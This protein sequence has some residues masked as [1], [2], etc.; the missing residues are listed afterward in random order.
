M[1][2]TKKHWPTSR[3]CAHG[4]VA[5]FAFVAVALAACS[6]GTKEGQVPT[7]SQ[8]N[9]V[10]TRLDSA[11]AILSDFRQKVPDDVANHAKCLIVFPGLKSGGLVVGGMSGK[12][13]GTCYSEGAWSNPAP[14]NIGGGTLGAQIGFQSVDTLSLAMSDRAVA[15]LDSGNFKVGAGLSASAGPVGT[16]VS[17]QSDI[18]SYATSSGLFAGATL[19][20][21]SI[22][23]DDDAT[24]ALYGTT[25]S[26]ADILH[27]RVKLPETPAVQRFRSAVGAA[28]VPSGVS[29]LNGRH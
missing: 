5:A 11:T 19:N 17:S 21:S 3:A 10:A 2:S 8:R 4:A 15:A 6:S 14:L 1:N 16:G 29:M 13:F 12:G 20:G 28:Y 24:R 18:V 23:A 27:R 25:A 9:E 7:E 22:S 26:T